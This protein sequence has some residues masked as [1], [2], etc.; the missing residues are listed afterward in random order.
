[1]QHKEL[2]RSFIEEISKLK[3]EYEQ[4]GGNIVLIINANHL[5]SSWL[6]KHVSTIDKKIGLYLKNLQGFSRGI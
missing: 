4:S 3:K 6:T 5:V 1:M 2:H